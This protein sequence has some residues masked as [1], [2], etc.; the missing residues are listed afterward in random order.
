MIGKNSTPVDLY[1]KEG[2]FIKG[3]NSLKECAEFLNVAWVTI[4][5]HVQGK[6]KTIHRKYIVHKR[7]C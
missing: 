6:I 7:I 5:K 3:F 2:E 1:T 4:S